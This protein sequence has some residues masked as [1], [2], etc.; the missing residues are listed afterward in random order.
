MTGEHVDCRAALDRLYEYIDGQ[1]GLAERD[2]IAAHLTVCRGC[3]SQFEIEQ[4]F[5]E[6]VVRQ[7]PR[8]TAR[9]EFKA[10]LLARLRE[11]PA[12]AVDTARPTVGGRLVK[13]LPWGGRFALAAAI[14]LALGL[15]AAWM[16]RQR[17]GAKIE[18]A[19]LGGY[20]HDMIEVEE[21]G[22]ETADF[23][24]A[25]EFVAQ[26]FCPE[27]AGCLPLQSPNGI[28]THDACII[29]WRSKKLAHYE[30]EA[31][32]RGGKLSIFVTPAA[33]FRFTDEPAVQIGSEVYHTAT[34]RCCRFVSW[35]GNDNYV[36]TLMG[37]C[38]IPQLLAWAEAWHGRRLLKNSDTSSPTIRGKSADS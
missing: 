21:D 37:D 19:V 18:W 36:C 38:P 31:P 30:L 13:I 27:A 5:H 23:G 8:P 12:G 22:L 6:F 15:G 24:Q 4:L 3:L 2:A 16:A 9:E 7:A 11:E 29:P 34:Y 35:R 17:G 25:R 10:R 32:D 20:H 1:L 33:E 14:L 26:H 28:V